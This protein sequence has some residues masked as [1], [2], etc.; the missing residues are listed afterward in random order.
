MLFSKRT[1]EPSGLLS[2]RPSTQQSLPNAFGFSQILCGAA[3]CGLLVS[4]GSQT[5][6]PPAPPVPTTN[7]VPAA[8]AAS[9]E[10]AKLVG[11]WERPDGGYILEIK[12]VDASG[13]LEAGYFNPNPINVS[14]AVGWRDKEET[15]V[16]VELRD[17]NYPGS[18][19]NLTYEPKT[20]QLYGQYFQATQQQTYE[21]TFA[22]VK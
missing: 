19:Y 3:L 12:S 16:I 4:C 18:T 11:K 1:T 15:K 13:K 22:R 2:L 6:T 14:R 17:V 7:A 5:A 9:P 8:A 21:V 20:D 10:V